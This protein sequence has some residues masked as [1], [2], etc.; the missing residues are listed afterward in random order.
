MQGLGFAL[1]GAV[2][3]V[4]RTGEF[5]PPRYCR[6]CGSEF[7]ARAYQDG[8]DQRTGQPVRRTFRACPNNKLTRPH[9]FLGNECSGDRPIYPSDDGDID[10]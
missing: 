8:Y 7:E 10:D 2:Q 4:T 6:T 9:G 1:A 3:R 5:A